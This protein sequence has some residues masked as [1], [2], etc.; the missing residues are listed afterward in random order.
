MNLINSLPST[1]LSD[2]ASMTDADRAELD[3]WFDSFTA[4]ILELEA[5]WDRLAELEAAW[6]RLAANVDAG[7]L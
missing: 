6:N 4:D 3:A 1:A 5:A 7:A 2:Y